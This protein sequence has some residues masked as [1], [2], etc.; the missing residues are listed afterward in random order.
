[1]PP[2]TARFKPRQH[3]RVAPGL[4]PGT[5]H[6]KGK[7][8]AYVGPAQALGQRSPAYYRVRLDDGR[9]IIASEE[10]LERW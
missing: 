5:P 4:R 7:V 10:R 1:M 6:G 2:S 8:V 9:V 3:V